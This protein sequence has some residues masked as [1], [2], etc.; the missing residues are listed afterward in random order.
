MWAGRLQNYLAVMLS[1]VLL[2]MVLG[3]GRDPADTDMLAPT[4][5]LGQSYERGPLYMDVDTGVVARGGAWLGRGMERPP[6]SSIDRS[7]GR[8]MSAKC[9]KC[10]GRGTQPCEHLCCIYG[11]AVCTDCDGSGVRS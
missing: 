8:D 9:K 5:V 11:A 3:C 10:I 7:R 4:V 1:F 6:P 2:A